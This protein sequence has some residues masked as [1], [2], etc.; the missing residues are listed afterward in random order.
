MVDPVGVRA[1]ARADEP[2]VRV[3]HRDRIHDGLFPCREHGDVAFRA[4]AL[5]LDEHAEVVNDDLSGSQREDVGTGESGSE[6][7][8]E[9]EVA[10]EPA[11]RCRLSFSP[12]EQL[13]LL[14][15]RV[16]AKRVV[17]VHGGQT[18]HPFV[19][20]EDGFRDAQEHGASRCPSSRRQGIAPGVDV[21]RDGVPMED[22]VRLQRVAGD[23]GDPPG[24]R[25]DRTDHVLGLVATGVVLLRG[26]GGLADERGDAFPLPRFHAVWGVGGDVHVYPLSRLIVTTLSVAVGHDKRRGTRKS[27]GLVG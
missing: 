1:P 27:P 23:L 14:E 2:A 20:V 7:Q 17:L 13:P 8:G 18:L 3:T 15:L 4:G 11:G 16:R 10:V 25:R 9:D 24:E 22:Y 5:D 12:G 21:V 6:A 26:E 19:R